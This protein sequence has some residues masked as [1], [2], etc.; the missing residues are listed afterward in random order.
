ASHSCVTHTPSTPSYQP[1]SAWSWP[2]CHCTR[3]H[4]HTHKHTH[5]QA[6]TH[7]RTHTLTQVRACHIKVPP[8]THT[9]AHRPPGLPQEVPAAVCLGVVVGWLF[10]QTLRNSL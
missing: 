2:N 10:V 4:T 8:N 9:H 7:T 6:H 1:C 5:K 3:T